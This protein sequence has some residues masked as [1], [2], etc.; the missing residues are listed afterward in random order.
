[1]LSEFFLKQSKYKTYTSI[2]MFI[3]DKLID[4]IAKK[5]DPIDK[6]K[7]QQNM[8]WNKNQFQILLLIKKLHLM[9]IKEK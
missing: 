5:L 3:K 9:K 4:N 1:M 7:I 2:F 6:W 8:L